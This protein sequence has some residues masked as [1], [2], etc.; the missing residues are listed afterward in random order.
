M[1]AMF[2]FI[3]NKDHTQFVINFSYIEINNEQVYD[4]LADGK[5]INDMDDIT[6]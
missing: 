6:S 5:E 2:A 4:L 1:E 3:F